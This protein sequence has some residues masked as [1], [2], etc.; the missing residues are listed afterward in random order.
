MLYACFCSLDVVGLLLLAVW[1]FVLV[2]VIGCRCRRLAIVIHWLLLSA[3]CCLLLVVCYLLLALLLLAWC[4]SIAVPR[5][6]DVVDFVSLTPRRWLAVIVC[7]LLPVFCHNNVVIVLLFLLYFLLY[8]Y[9]CC[10]CLHIIGLLL[11]WL[12][13]VGLLLHWL[14]VVGLLSFACCHSLA[15]V[16]G[17]LSFYIL[18]FLPVTFFIHSLEITKL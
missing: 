5:S 13:V 12:A 11:R 15:A 1:L 16:V 6:L 2:V 10:I 18:L 17:L 4:R 7:W 14:A 8:Y 9:R 3:Y